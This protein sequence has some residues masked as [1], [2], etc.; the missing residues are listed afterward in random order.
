M[1]KNDLKGVICAV[2]TPLKNGKPDTDNL[3]K[4]LRQLENDGCEGVLLLGTTGEGPSMG[5]AEREEIV[6]AAVAA[7]TG[8][9]ILVGTG[10]PSLTDT[11]YLTRR[12]FELGA[13]V[14]VTLPPYY[15]KKVADEAMVD[16]F[17]QVF[18]EAVPDDKLL[19]LYHIPQ[20]SG[21]PVTFGVI[22]GLLTYAGNR[23]AAL[24]DSGGDIEFSRELCHKFP[25]LRVFVGSDKLL[26]DG[27]CAG[28][29]GCITAAANVIAPLAVQT[30]QTFI[31]GEEAEAA[32][33]I[34]TRARML[35]DNYQP[36]P[37]SLKAILQHRYGAEGWEVRPPLSPLSEAQTQALLEKLAA[38]VPLK[39]N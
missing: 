2:V 30:Y 29:A 38:F 3:Q 11:I 14:A 34:L 6:S 21:M 32:Q 15:F 7:K 23:M 4:L 1:H 16:Y 35:L 27:L 39:V 18:D 17:R 13:D 37:P 24:K 28:A 31:A 36:F 12:A 22:D 8:M 25:E 20:V 10:T 33:E 26:L 9:K 19:M 5:M